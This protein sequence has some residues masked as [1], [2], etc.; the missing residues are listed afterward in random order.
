MAVAALMGGCS[1]VPQ[2]DREPKYDFACPESNS[3][4]C[5]GLYGRE[6]EHWYAKT[7]GPDIQPYEPSARL[8][9]DGMDKQR[10]MFLPPGS[11]IDANNPNDWVFPNGTR[12]WKEFAWH[13]KRVETRYIEKRAGVWLR[14]TFRWTD[15]QTNALELT[16]GLRNVPGT[17]GDSYEIPSQTQCDTCHKNGAD[18][19][20]GFDQILMAS[21]GAT[22][23]TWREL[24]E[25]HAVEPA[26]S[27]IAIPGTPR[28]QA[29]MGYL[30]A[31]CGVSCH[32]SHLQ[33]P[34]EWT[35][36]RMKLEVENL[37]TVEQ[38][39]VYRTGVGLGSYI[40]SPELG[41]WLNL[42]EPGKPDASAIVYR[43]SKRD[44][45]WQ[46]PPIATHVIDQNG[47]DALRAWIQ[48][49]PPK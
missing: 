15:D 47:L 3:L 30:H 19:V 24:N 23:F 41:A 10:Y 46:M 2:G 26:L 39:N 38:T 12:F 8:W 13:G 14:T 9:S 48:E 6:G 34:A 42:I 32:N 40:Y 31:N 44:D 20:L 17:D 33:A 5:T 25:R 22:G 1:A 18:F 28:A 29:A 43:A 37:A 21:D 36:F 16:E 11:A 45:F 27:P 7:L 49:L 4:A 35:Q